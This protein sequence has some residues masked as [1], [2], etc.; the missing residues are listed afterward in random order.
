MLTLKAILKDGKIYFPDE[1]PPVGEHKVL[2]TILDEEAGDIVI[3]ENRLNR[4]RVCV[5]DEKALLNDRQTKILTLASKGFK[6]K[7]I[8]E[9]LEMTFG[10][11][12][13]QLSRIYWKLEESYEKEYRT[14]AWHFGAAS[15]RGTT[16]IGVGR[17]L[18]DLDSDSRFW[19]TCQPARLQ[20]KLHEK[21]GRSRPLVGVQSW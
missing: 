9:E 21:S 15:C 17:A 4:M 14:S 6:S 1:L 13:N 18:P 10:A 5:L 8:G 2:V 19:L 3:S 20:E 12:R 11:V 16:G 7:E